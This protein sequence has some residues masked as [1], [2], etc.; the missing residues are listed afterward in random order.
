MTKGTFVFLTNDAKGNRVIYMT[1]EFNGCMYLDDGGYGKEVVD[2]FEEGFDNLDQFKAYVKA[3]NEEHFQYPEKLV[4]RITK[5]EIENDT[6]TF[7]GVDNF[8]KFADWSYHSDYYFWY[9]NTDDDIEVLAENGVVQINSSGGAVFNYRAFKETVLDSGLLKAGDSIDFAEEAEIYSFM[10]AGLT[11]EE[12]EEISGYS[13]I[14]EVCGIYDDLEDYGR[15]VI[16]ESIGVE[17]WLEDYI[18]YER[19]ARDTVSDD[20]SRLLSS[21]RVI[22]YS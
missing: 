15:S 9:N 3:F 10:N 13:Y 22:T 14:H 1:T 19:Y 12:A 16:T 2:R 18:D 5:K 20:G 21:G 7:D 6:F 8:Y 4:W 11:R 17:S